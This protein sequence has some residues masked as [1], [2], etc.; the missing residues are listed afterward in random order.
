MCWFCLSEHWH[1]PSSKNLNPNHFTWCVPLRDTLLTV[2]IC[3]CPYESLHITMSASVLLPEP[4]FP[5]HKS[6]QV[7]SSCSH[8]SVF[9]L[10]SVHSSQPVLSFSPLVSDGWSSST[11]IIFTYSFINPPSS[12]FTKF[13]FCFTSSEHT[14]TSPA[15][16]LPAPYSLQMDDSWNK[17]NIKHKTNK[18]TFWF[19]TSRLKIFL[20]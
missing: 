2:S 10:I 14:S 9:N 8:P 20:Q 19:P 15:S 1:W 17:E 12:L 16:L 5:N 4:L 7:S 11:F 13:G 6:E 18:C 3:V